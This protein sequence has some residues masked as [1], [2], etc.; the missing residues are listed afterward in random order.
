MMERS[1]RHETEPAAPP[2]P[3]DLHPCYAPNAPTEEDA[4]VI[5]DL[6]AI[7]K[8]MQEQAVLVRKS[9]D[10]Y[11][12]L[13]KSKADELKRRQEEE[14]PKEGVKRLEEEDLLLN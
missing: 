2:A 3:E 9:T 7:S 14:T 5:I 4:S 6:T 8:A 12:V 10:K 13:P 1:T 11:E